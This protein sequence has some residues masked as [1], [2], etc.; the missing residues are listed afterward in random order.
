MYSSVWDALLSCPCLLPRPVHHLFSGEQTA[1]ALLKVRHTSLS[2]SSDS[3]QCTVHSGKRQGWVMQ[4]SRVPAGPSRLMI[5]DHASQGESM[6][7]LQ[8]L[9]PVLLFPIYIPRLLPCSYLLNHLYQASWVECGVPWAPPKHLSQTAILVACCA[10]S[11]ALPHNSH[12]TSLSLNAVFIFLSR[13]YRVGSEEII[14]QEHN[15]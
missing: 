11:L 3:E 15:N 1:R 8:R 7:Q 4:T 10:C 6:N 12:W 13:T 9:T 14:F 5:H 2:S